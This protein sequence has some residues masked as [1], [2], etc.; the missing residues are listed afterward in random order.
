MTR[1]LGPIYWVVMPIVLAVIGILILVSETGCTP[2]PKLGLAAEQAALSVEL[3]YQ[4]A[5]IGSLAALR[6]E[7]DP[8]KRR[9][10]AGLDE[11]AYRA[12][13]L[14]RAAY[15]RRDASTVEDVKVARLAVSAFLYQTGC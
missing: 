7:S 12:V 2:R 1:T 8:A 4:A 9:C 6:V 14:A 11:K 3:A 5:A 15:D 10:I 13:K